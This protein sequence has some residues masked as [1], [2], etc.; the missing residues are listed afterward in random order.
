M[1]AHSSVRITA[2]VVAALSCLALGT[3]LAHAWGNEGHRMVNR[4]AAETLPADA[5]AFMRSESAIDEIEYLGPEPDRWR[6]PAE[7]ELLAMQ[8]PEHYIDLELADRWSAA[9]PPLRFRGQGFRCRATTGKDRSATMAG[10]R[11]LATAQ[12]RVARYR[13]YPPRIRTHT[14]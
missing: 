6:S 3:P 9:P 13:N 4:L 5:P 7:P 1:F 2:T 8:A 10:R 11:N 12:G 14:A